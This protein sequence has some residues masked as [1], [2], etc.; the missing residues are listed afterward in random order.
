MVYLFSPINQLLRKLLLLQILQLQLRV[1]HLF[2][3]KVKES[4]INYILHKGYLFEQKF[5]QIMFIIIIQFSAATST[6]ISPILTNGPTTSNDLNTSTVESL[7]EAEN[8]N[9]NVDDI[10]ST[11][12]GTTVIR[13]IL[14]ICKLAP[15]SHNAS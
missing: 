14:L 2:H 6:S 7:N 11:L 8:V 4:A 3:Q 5:L 10:S 13:M 1:L 9:S 12:K 15:Y